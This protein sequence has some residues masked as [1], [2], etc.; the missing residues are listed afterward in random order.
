MFLQTYMHTVI[1]QENN[2]QDD[3]FSLH[4]ATGKLKVEFSHELC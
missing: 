4:L 3:M 2:V 1:C